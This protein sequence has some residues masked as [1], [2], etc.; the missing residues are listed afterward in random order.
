LVWYKDEVNDK[1]FHVLGGLQRLTTLDGYV[2]PLNIKDGLACLNIRQHTDHEYETLPRVF[3]TSKVEWDL[4]VLDHEFTDESQWVE[5]KPEIIDLI[6]ASAYNEFGQYR[7]RVEVNKHVYI[8]SFDSDN[9]TDHIN[10]CVVN[11]HSTEVEPDPS[12]I[13]VPKTINKKSPDY[14]NLLYFFGWLDADT[15]KNTFEHTTQYARLPV[16]TTIRCAFRSPNPALNV[17]H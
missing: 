3:L 10:Q 7:H 2:I 15:I 17:V 9:I 8:S 12:T 14:N 1:S 16:D 6:S 13:N 4:T 5:D 11:A